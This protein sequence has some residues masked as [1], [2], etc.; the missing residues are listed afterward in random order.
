[1][2]RTDRPDA[3]TSGAA[4]D[5]EVRVS[6]RQLDL[7]RRDVLIGAAA[8]AAL[9]ALPRSAR[10]AGDLSSV[11][12]Q[13]DKQMGESVARLQEWIRQPSISAQNIGIQECCDL[14]MRLL[15]DAGFGSASKIPT[16]GHPGILATYEAGA[17]R[18]LAVYFMYDV[19]Q[20]EEKEWSV[21][22]FA[23]QL[24][25]RPEVGKVLMGRG[26]VNQKG[27]EASFLAALHAIR[28]AGQ[29]LP[30]NLVLVAEG[31][32]ELGS[33]HFSQIVQRPEVQAALRRCSGIMLPSA[34]Q[35][36][37][38]E[39]NVT[40]G[41][42]GVLELELESSGEKWGRGPTRDI[43]SGQKP[44]VDSPVWHLVQAL[45]TL[46][47][48]DGNDPAIDGIESAVR[49][50]SADEKRMVD[51]L[52]R[53]LDEKLMMKEL[54]IQH[55]A[56]DLDF[57]TTLERLV[58]RPTV[59]IEGIVGG[60]TGPGGKTILP[61]R[62]LAKVDIRLVPEMKAKEVLA[63]VRGHLAKRG[64]GDIEVRQLGGY[65]PNTTSKDAGPVQTAVAVY[66]KSGIE[67]L[68]WPR[69]G[70]SWPGFYFT[71]KPLQLPAIHFGLGYGHGA[72][73][74]DE[75]YVIES[76]KPKVQGMAGAI[77]SFVDYLYA[78]AS[79]SHA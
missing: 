28:A 66:R 70:G 62:A 79:P 21:P 26:A 11:H 12:A 35:N 64:Y 60:Y 52:A 56:R 30:V 50:L 13:V 59:N 69:S 8:G 37:A 46:V 4:R 55:W 42:K 54:S 75:F 78:F 39:I 65:D 61:H 36:V 63:A 71:E 25:D 45:S 73:S 33:P 14:T 67:P 49:P 7:D 15:R 20:V 22:P 57:R 2:N 19:K 68:L 29:K 3:W 5:S 72:H 18:T 27:P 51:E 9:F 1:M 41:A 76:A 47:A 32:E 24:V 16:E 74:K 44:A 34:A 43:H 23:A 31:E 6:P 58:S 17:K 48:P 38:G 77:H 53:R 10:A 40:L